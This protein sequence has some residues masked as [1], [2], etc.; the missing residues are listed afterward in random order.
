MLTANLTRSPRAANGPEGA[1]C[2]RVRFGMMVR[3]LR[4]GHG[5]TQE[6]MAE[7]LDVSLNFLNLIERGQRA[8]S[9][10]K[11]ERLARVLRVAIFELF[12]FPQAI[13]KQPAVRS[14]SGS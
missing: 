7:K 3:E 1:A 13:P 12:V 2:V 9:F 8:P 10:D 4:F 6:K 5:Y 14:R 11:L